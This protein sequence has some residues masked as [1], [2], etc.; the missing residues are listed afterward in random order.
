MS[1]KTVFRGVA[2]AM[3]TPMKE[4]G[5]INYPVFQELL[6]YQIAHQ[7]DAVVVA[8]TTGESA[9]LTDE[10]HID[11][12]RFAVKAAK[13]R[14]PI[15]AG[16]GSNNTAHAVHLSKECE[17]AGADALL[18]V[19][20]YYNKASQQGLFL[21]FQAC[22]KATNI[23]IILYNVPSRTGVNIYPATYK[24][25]SALDNIVACKEASGNFSQIAKI[26]SLCKD[27]LSIYSGNDD[28]ITSS[29]ALGGKGVISVMSNIIP[30]ETHQICQAFF[31]GDSTTSD[32]IQMKYLDLIEALF[33]DVN[34]IPIKQAMQAMGFDVGKCRLPLCD[35]D[36]T[37]A[38]KLYAVLKA[39]GL[40]AGDVK[41]GSVTVH[42]VQ[43]CGN[44]IRTNV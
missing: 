20:P 12:I 13:G 25:L 27:D 23:P 21:H 36:P 4:D 35:L 34:P 24:R 8:G 42:R 18:H 28:Q 3:I 17:K 7:A 33:I 40:L 43:N 32:T 39:Y 41:A 14:I 26:A 15:I 38:E 29:L 5:S 37:N 2:T 31:D 22:S 30:E 6:E 1:K 16:A 11:L 9:T 44:V 19:T 10:E